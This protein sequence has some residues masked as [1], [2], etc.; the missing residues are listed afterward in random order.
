LRGRLGPR[1]RI[2]RIEDHGDGRV[3][4]NAINVAASRATGMSFEVRDVDELH[5]HR[6]RLVL[7]A[8]DSA[9]PTA[10]RGEGSSRNLS[11]SPRSN[12]PGPP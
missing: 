11:A 12:S 7:V 1:I 6:G 8:S 5:F 2:D 10:V 4:V 9:T 3:A